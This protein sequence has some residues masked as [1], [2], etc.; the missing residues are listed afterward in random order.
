MLWGGTFELDRVADRLISSGSMGLGT[1]E[2]KNL[3][4]TTWWMF[5]S[6]GY[7]LVM[8]WLARGNRLNQAKVFNR[9]WR[10]PAAITIKYLL[11]DLL[12]F[13]IE[14]SS[15]GPVLAGPRTLAGAVVLGGLIMMYWSAT[16]PSEAKLIGRLVRSWI[17]GLCVATV[18][19]VVSM[20]IDQFFTNDRLSAGGLFADPERAEQ[21]ALSIFWSAFALGSVVAGFIWRAAPLW[22][23]GLA[24]FAMVLL[25]AVTID[26]SQASTGYRI[27]SFI[28]LGGLLLGTSVLYGKLSPKLLAHETAHPPDE[29]IK[30][31]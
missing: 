29:A 16:G 8:H 10:L 24:L 23:F 5:C 6:C 31:V 18:F 12:F 30:E 4:W 13:R 7:L 14:G 22:Y 27:L 25:K 19:L 9:V 1:L 26:L 15:F 11:F 17:V 28:G 21:V 3:L 2:W 20:C